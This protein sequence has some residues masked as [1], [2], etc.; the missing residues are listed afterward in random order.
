MSFPWDSPGLPAGERCRWHKGLCA[1]HEADPAH[2][3]YCHTTA[4]RCGCRT[5]DTTLP[6]NIAL[7]AIEAAKTGKPAKVLQEEFGLSHS[8]AV[9][10]VRRAVGGKKSER[11][12]EEN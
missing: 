9:S 1:Y 12:E 3:T 5:S 6:L 10:L 2:C 7:S 4:G 11:N 8:V